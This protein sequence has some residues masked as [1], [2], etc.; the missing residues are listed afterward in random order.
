MFPGTRKWWALCAKECFLSHLHKI[1][2]KNYI[3]RIFSFPRLK[4]WNQYSFQTTVKSVVSEF[5]RLRLAPLKDHRNSEISCKNTVTS[6]EHRKRPDS[7][8]RYLQPLHLSFSSDSASASVCVWVCFCV[9]LC[10]CLCLSASAYDA[11][12]KLPPVSNLM[13]C[14]CLFLSFCLWLHLYVCVCV[15]VFV[16]AC[17]STYAYAYAY[18]SASDYDADGNSH[19]DSLRTVIL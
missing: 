11:G 10:I 18:A 13:L 8:E 7:W 3:C 16:Y 4:I 9:C 2:L 15:C 17:A 19:S 6:F 12:G 14:L 1:V 5:R